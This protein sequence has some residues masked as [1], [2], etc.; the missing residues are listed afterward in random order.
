M[1]NA[2]ASDS[3]TF[4]GCLD[5]WDPPV[6]HPLAVNIRFQAAYRFKIVADS[7]GAVKL[8]DQDEDGKVS[9][10]LL[11]SVRDSLGRIRVKSGCFN[12]ELSVTLRFET[13]PYDEDDSAIRPSFA[14]KSPEEIVFRAM[15]P[16]IQ[17]E[18]KSK[19]E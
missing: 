18:G 4:L 13:Y 14:I 3:A 11:K 17:P 15:A 6:F 2:M 7:S 12:K 5:S 1:P 9:R 10:L 16:M 8:F 19:N